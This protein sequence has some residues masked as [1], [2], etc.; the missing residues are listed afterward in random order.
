MIVF[1]D[2]GVLGLVTSPSNRDEAR[3]CK[4]WLFQLM[5]RSVYVVTSDICDYEIRRNLLLVS[6]TDSR[7]NGIDNLDALAEFVQLLPLSQFVLKRAAK[8]WS[9]AHR[10]GIPTADIKNNEKLLFYIP[11]NQQ[12]T[13]YQLSRNS[14]FGIRN[15]ER[16]LLICRFFSLFEGASALLGSYQLP[17]TNSPETNFGIRNSE[18]GPLTCSFSSLFEGARALRGSY[19]LIPRNILSAMQNSDDH[20]LIGIVPKIDNSSSIG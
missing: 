3:A 6:A 10:Q 13:N 18:M 4:E 20:N 5:A 2:T 15:S 14:E 7:A 1:L 19:P 11:N 9:K 16:G 12:P 17:T 8:L